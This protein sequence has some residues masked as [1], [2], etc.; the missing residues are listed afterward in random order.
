M[1]PPYLVA[2]KVI[3]VTC[4][5]SEVVVSMLAGVGG[6]VVVVVGGTGGDSP[7]GPPTQIGTRRPRQT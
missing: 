2:G 1:G 5:G 3:G 6:D 4:S 7:G